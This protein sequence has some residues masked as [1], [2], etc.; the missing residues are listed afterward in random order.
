MVLC[1]HRLADKVALRQIAANCGEEVECVN[2]LNA[3]RNHTHVQLVAQGDGRS[4]QGQ[5]SLRVPSGQPGQ[6]TAVEL[7]FA[8]GQAA[9]VGERRD[10]GTEV[11]NRD[12][13]SEVP[14]LLNDDLTE[15]EVSDD[16]GLC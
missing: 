2:I 1:G 6:E 5:I 14:Q 12:T 16:G 3:L 8:D 9:Q 11:V 13:Q 10:S 15:V 4:N 7:Q